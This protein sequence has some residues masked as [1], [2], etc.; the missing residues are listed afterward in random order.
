MRIYRLV[1]SALSQNPLSS[2][3]YEGR[4]H[5]TSFDKR[6]FLVLPRMRITSIQIPMLDLNLA[7]LIERNLTKELFRMADNIKGAELQYSKDVPMF[8]KFSPNQGNISFPLKWRKFICDWFYV[9]IQPI[10]TIIRKNISLI[11]SQEYSSA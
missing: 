6:R 10:H 1:K 4:N 5:I 3:I 2:I 9:R 11:V 7:V 8:L